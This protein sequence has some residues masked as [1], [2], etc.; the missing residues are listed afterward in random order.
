MKPFLSNKM[1]KSSSRT[2]EN[3]EILKEETIMAE[4]FHTF[5][6]NIVTYFKIAPYIRSDF[7]EAF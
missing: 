2:V 3:D 1:V 4:T 6:T 7:T 5:F